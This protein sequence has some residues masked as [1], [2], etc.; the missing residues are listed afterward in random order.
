[1]AGERI[2]GLIEYS[3]IPEMGIEGSS[4][5]H[6]VP[7]DAIN[8]ALMPIADKAGEILHAVGVTVDH[9]LDKFT[10]EKNERVVQAN[11]PALGSRVVYQS[12]APTD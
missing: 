7:A 4:K 1:M 9:L 12:S 6:Y 3:S 5:D 2:N 8:A 11:E 10:E